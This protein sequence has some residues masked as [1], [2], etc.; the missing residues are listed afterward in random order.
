M[1]WDSKGLSSDDKK[2]SKENF[3]ILTG[4]IEGFRLSNWDY[5]LYIGFISSKYIVQI[6]ILGPSYWLYE[7]GYTV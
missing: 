3:I 4:Q 7:K 6:E 1:L 5:K 2:H